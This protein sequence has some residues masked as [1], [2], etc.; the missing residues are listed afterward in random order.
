MRLE[1]AIIGR[2]VSQ[3]YDFLN[4]YTTFRSKASYQLVDPA[5]IYS[6][7]RLAADKVCLA[8]A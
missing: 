4:V 6:S 8:F 7:I 1:N 5:I 3:P 2:V